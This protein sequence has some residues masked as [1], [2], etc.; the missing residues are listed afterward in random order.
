MTVTNN[1]LSRPEIENIIKQVANQLI[2]NDQKRVFPSH[3]QCVLNAD[4]E[5]EEYDIHVHDDRE[6]P[7]KANEKHIL[8]AVT[9]ILQNEL[10]P[11]QT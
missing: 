10:T 2:E 4:T 3:E 7:R 5:R 8:N 6:S 9:Q 11:I 1:R